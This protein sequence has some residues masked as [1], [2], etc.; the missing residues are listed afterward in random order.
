[1]LQRRSHNNL[2]PLN[3]FFHAIKESNVNVPLLIE[4]VQRYIEM[5]HIALEANRLIEN[6]PAMLRCEGTIDKAEY[7]L[8]LLRRALD[9]T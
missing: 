7:L 6:E 9:R 5:E 1:M 2:M 8:C 3:E 4:T